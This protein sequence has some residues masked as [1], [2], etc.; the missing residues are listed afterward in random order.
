[1]IL[2]LIIYIVHDEIPSTVD[3]RRPAPPVKYKTTPKMVR[4]TTY[5][6]SS[7]GSLPSTV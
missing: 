4:S 6:V 2:I 1:M 7:A 3:G 5:Q